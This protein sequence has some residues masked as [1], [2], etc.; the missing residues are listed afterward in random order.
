M[1]YDAA[2]ETSVCGPAVTSAPK[3]AETA[4]PQARGVP[5]R[6]ARVGQRRTDAALAAPAEQPAGAAPAAA[7]G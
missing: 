1:R 5:H 2:A 3:P 6:Q 7:V 4:A